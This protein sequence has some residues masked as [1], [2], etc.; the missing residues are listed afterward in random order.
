MARCSARGALSAREDRRK[1]TLLLSL[2]RP[3]LSYASVYRALL[4]LLC[5]CG[6]EE[7]DY[8]AITR[9][10]FGLETSGCLDA[11]EAY[12]KPEFLDS[13]CFFFPRM[14]IG[15][16]RTLFLSSVLSSRVPELYRNR[17]GARGKC[18]RCREKSPG[19]ERGRGGCAIAGREKKNAKSGQPLIVSFRERKWKG[20]P[21]GKRRK[22]RGR[23]FAVIGR[24]R[25]AN[26]I[27]DLPS[28]D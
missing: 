9:L 12:R 16:L 20:K 19:L 22:E 2:Q 7:R 11:P 13:L 17:V 21:G 8:R 14:S 5:V 15:S 27:D 18:L 10:Y 24:L 26:T 4:M 28:A 23:V 3:P 25:R 1:S 6:R